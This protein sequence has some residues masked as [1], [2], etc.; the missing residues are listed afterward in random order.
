MLAGTSCGYRQRGDLDGIAEVLQTG[1]EAVDLLALAALIEV[2]AAEVFI[3]GAALQ[4]F[5][6][7]GQ[8]RGGDATKRLFSA[9]AGAEAVELRLEIAGFLARGGPGGLDEGG[10]QSRGSLAHPDGSSLAGTLV[11]SR[12]QAGPGD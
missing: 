12:A 2:I 4:H 3:E 9:A 5:I 7:G 8:D 1:N 11:V 10:L 6:G